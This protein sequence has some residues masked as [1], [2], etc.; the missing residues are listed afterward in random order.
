M[1]IYLTVPVGQEF[2]SGLAELLWLR[3]SY[4]IEDKLLP[5]SVDI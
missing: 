1:N 4:D 2:R 5:G 3:F